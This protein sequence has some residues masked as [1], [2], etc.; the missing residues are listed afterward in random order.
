MSSSERSNLEQ[1]PLILSGIVMVDFIFKQDRPG[2]SMFS[3][4]VVVEGAYGLSHELLLKLWVDEDNSIFLP[5]EG[6]LFQL[7]GKMTKTDNGLEL[8]ALRFVPME[9]KEGKVPPP[10][11]NGT[12]SFLGTQQEGMVKVNS[13]VYANCIAGEM[14]LECKHTVKQYENF[15]NKARKD[16]EIYVCGVLADIDN[17]SNVTLSSAHFS[18]LGKSRNAMTLANGVTKVSSVNQP[19]TLFS[20]RKK[21]SDTVKPFVTTDNFDEEPKP[22]PEV[23]DVPDSPL[24][25]SDSFNRFQDEAAADEPKAKRKYVRK[26]KL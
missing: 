10:F 7:E 5:V 13:A 18:F 19:G 16:Q 2:A 8:E 12:G 14:L 25:L 11:I 1:M 4:I 6:G 15:V 3:V 23:P 17:L 20:P 9:L 26:P 21:R 22:I 24:M